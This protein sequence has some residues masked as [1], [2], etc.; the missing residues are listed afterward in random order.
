MSNSSLGFAF[1]ESTEKIKGK[2]KTKKSKDEDD[3]S[4]ANMPVAKM[5]MAKLRPIC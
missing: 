3:M 2:L 5:P 4:M 1:I